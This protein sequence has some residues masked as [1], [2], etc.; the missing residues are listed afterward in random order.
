MKSKHL[1]FKNETSLKLPVFFLSYWYFLIF[2]WQ[3]INSIHRTVTCSAQSVSKCQSNNI[4]YEIS[5]VITLYFWTYDMGGMVLW[6]GRLV[7]R[8]LCD[9]WWSGILY[10]KVSL[11]YSN[12]DGNILFVTFMQYVNTMINLYWTSRKAL[13][14]N[15]LPRK[16]ESKVNGL[17]SHYGCFI[18]TWQKF[19]CNMYKW[20]WCWSRLCHF[21]IYSD[22][23]RTKTGPQGN[24]V[25]AAGQ[26]LVPLHSST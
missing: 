8:R 23:L 14:F 2:L 1:H 6:R 11:V 21:M 4:E 13:C 9:K 10:L 22:Q 12:S 18:I 19:G 26:K 7:N 17:E 20:C 16:L 25:M 5:G 3:T 15:I 24:V